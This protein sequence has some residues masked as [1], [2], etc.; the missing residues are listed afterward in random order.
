MNSAECLKY[1]DEGDRSY[2][3]AGMALAAFILDY[4]KYISSVSIERRGLD[5]V[6]FTP[7]F[8]CG[9]GRGDIGQGI[10]VAY[11]GAVSGHCFDAHIKC[12]VPQNGKRPDRT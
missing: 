6:E 1:K 3:V 5:S 9:V 2:G 8:F 11:I 7:E 12:D 10:M 4:E